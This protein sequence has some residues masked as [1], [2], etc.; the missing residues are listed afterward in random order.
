[1]GLK[2]EFSTVVNNDGTR[3]KRIPGKGVKRTKTFDYQMDLRD[4][5]D[6]LFLIMKHFDFF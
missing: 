4:V 5:S 2:M 1:M 6:E 3:A